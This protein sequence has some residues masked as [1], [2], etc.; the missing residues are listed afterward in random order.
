MRFD[1][2]KREL[3]LIKKLLEDYYAS[4]LDDESD[5]AENKRIKTLLID[6]IVKLKSCFDVGE[7][8]EANYKS[9]L[10]D[11]LQTFSENTG[12]HEDAAILDMAVKKFISLNIINSAQVDELVR[13]APIAR[14]H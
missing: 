12:S 7:I 13:R 10:D 5:T 11:C 6:L 2:L 8:S 1:D 14:W 9:L 4:D 3:D